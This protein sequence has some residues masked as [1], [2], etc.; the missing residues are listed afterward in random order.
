VLAKA[1]YHWIFDGV[2]E[3]G[4]DFPC[5]PGMFDELI[6]ITSA[7]PLRHGRSPGNDV[8]SITYGALAVKRPV[9][10]GCRELRPWSTGNGLLSRVALQQTLGGH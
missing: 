10:I 2:V 3:V 1:R 8:G 7:M 9:T 6:C 5:G 4:V